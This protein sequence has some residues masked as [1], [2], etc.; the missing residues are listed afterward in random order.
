MRARGFVDYARTKILHYLR[1]TSP[2]DYFAHGT[3][4]WGPSPR[5]AY[6][7]GLAP[8]CDLYLSI[9]L[10]AGGASAKGQVLLVSRNNPPN[11]QIRLAKVFV[12]YVDPLGLGLRQGGIAQEEPNNPAIML[13]NQN[14]RRGKYLYFELEFMDGAHSSGGQGQYRYGELI[15]EAR[16]NEIAEQ[17]VA[18]IVESQ[19]NIQPNLDAVTYR[20]TLGAPILW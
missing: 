15:E 3:K 4:A 8:E 9:H 5:L 7:N 10:N 13:G 1:Q 19:L 2:Q 18:G 17:V 14:Q 12:K 6:L 20:S 16:I 11:A